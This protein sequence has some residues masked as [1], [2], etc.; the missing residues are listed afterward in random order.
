MPT[1]ENERYA[2]WERA[3]E[4]TAVVP[5][6]AFVLVHVLDYARV[7]GGAQALGSRRHPSA[8]LVVVELLLVWLPLV[9]HAALSFWIWRRRRATQVHSPTATAHRLAGVVTGVFLVDHFVRFRLPILRGVTHSGDSLVRLA[10]ELS[11]TRGGVPW[12]AAL[13]LAGVVGVAFHLTLGLL[14]IVARSE[15]L[16]AS[17]AARA[18][19]FAAGV[20]AGLAG[21]LTILRLA[22]GG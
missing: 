15:R 11:S 2:R 3:F 20:L 22:T 9:G 1:A 7:L 18:S 14:R 5:L 16:R 4:L 6:A 8:P 13:H 21:V 17:R 12:V 19:S 10:A